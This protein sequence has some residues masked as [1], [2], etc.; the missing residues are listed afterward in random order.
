MKYKR[1][2]VAWDDGDGRCFI[3]DSSGKPDLPGIVVVSDMPK[4]EGDQLCA[5]LNTRPSMQEGVPSG[6]VLAKCS[7]VGLATAPT[8]RADLWEKARGMWAHGHGPTPEL[9]IQDAAAKAKA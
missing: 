9:A 4:E 2:F 3:T 7:W 8:Y 5:L 6:W 1:P